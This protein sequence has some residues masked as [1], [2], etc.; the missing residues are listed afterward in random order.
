M[1]EIQIHFLGFND[2]DTFRI[3]TGGSEALRVDSSQNLLVGKTSSGLNTAGV[4]FASSGRSRFTR[5]GN[6]VAEF[7]RKT[8]DGSIVSFNKDATA[9]GAIGVLN[10]NNLTIT[11]NTADHGGLQFGTHEI[12]PMEAGADANGTINL[13]SANSR[14]KDLHLS[15]DIFGTSNFDIRS[16]GNIFNTYGNSSSVFFRTQDELIDLPLIVQ[17]I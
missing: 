3:T 7:N 6:N 5:D 11:C 16:T 4:E 14:F 9:I 15:G 2:A 10:S 12:T 17:E 1:Q 8:S 13:G